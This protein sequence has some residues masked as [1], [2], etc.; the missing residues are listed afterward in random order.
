MMDGDRGAG[1]P[2]GT[3]RQKMAAL[4][5][6]GR[7][8]ARDLARNLRAPMKVVIDDLE[9]LRRSLRAGEAWAVDAAGCETC[10]FVFEGR[11]KVDR[12]SRCPAC[13]GER[14]RE[15]AFGIEGEPAGGPG[16]GA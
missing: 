2:E 4:L 1:K 15:A 6:Q 11:E 3:R 12:P 7:W 14:I 5:R 9:H 10:G 16:D 13:R 8:T